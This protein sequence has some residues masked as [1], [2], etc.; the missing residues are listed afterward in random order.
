MSR[1]DAAVERIDVISMACWS[2]ESAIA[3]R[4][5]WPRL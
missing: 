5:S 3:V 2:C 1:T 4:M